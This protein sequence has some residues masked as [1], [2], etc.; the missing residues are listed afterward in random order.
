M[1]RTTILLPITLLL[2][3]GCSRNGGSPADA[4]DAVAPELTE[5]DARRALIE[6]AENPDDRETVRRERL[7]DLRAGKA[8]DFVP[9]AKAGI[10]HGETW[11]VCLER[12]K[13]NFFT[14]RGAHTWTLDGRF[15]FKDDRWVAI[16]TGQARGFHA[17]KD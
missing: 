17:P 12:R 7:D 16:V 11:T 15:E 6:L 3:A 5:A 8:L 4:G 10:Y 14:T 1:V 9:A 13:F 2:L